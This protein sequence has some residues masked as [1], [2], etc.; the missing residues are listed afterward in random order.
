MGMAVGNSR[1]E[2]QEER[3][4]ASTDAVA[5]AA[6]SGRRHGGRPA[7]PA[8]PM[9]PPRGMVMSLAREDAALAVHALER[10]AAA[11]DHAGQGVFCH[12]HRQ[13]R[14]FGEQP[15]EVAQQRSAAREHH[16][17]LGDVGAQFGRGLLQGVLDGG[18]DLV[19]R[20]GERL[21]HFIAGDGEAA[22]HALG[23]VAALDL[24]LAHLGA[25]EGRTDALLDGLGRGLADQH[26]VVAADVADD[27]L[28]E[29]VAAHADAALVHHA[30]QG[31]HADF[32]RA[33]ADIHDHGAR[34]L[35][36]RQA[37]ADAGGHGFLD[38][39]DGGGARGLGRILDGAALHLGGA[40][41][42][43]D[44]D[45]RARREQRARVHHL[46]ELLD[47]LLGDHEVGDH[48]ILHGPDGLDVAGHLAEHGLGLAADRLDD[49]LAVGAAFVADGDDGGLVEHDALV[50]GEDQRVGCAKINGKVGG[51]VPTESS[52]HSGIPLGHGM[53]V[54]LPSP[55]VYRV[56]VGFFRTMTGGGEGI[57]AKPG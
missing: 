36:D 23:E 5:N 13:A 41:G 19:E 16:A 25:G 22:R 6:P 48:A 57:A 56:F 2:C 51:E 34:G 30:A 43:A 32:R 54:G 52:E 40:A 14:L 20:I 12:Q 49:F 35:G 29:L 47:H 50:T 18:N 53:R 24:H 44:D 17:A 55:G 7:R 33:A 45:A 3:C 1:R 38:E 28:V 27:G 10:D 15:V 37:G 26:A 9:P 8:D 4:R 46:D 11:A 42:H 31:D 39:I 21:Q